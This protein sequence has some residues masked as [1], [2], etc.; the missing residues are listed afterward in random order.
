[1]VCNFYISNHFGFFII[2]HLV[3][4]WGFHLFSLIPNISNGCHEVGSMVH[5]DW[6]K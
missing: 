4:D 1:M 6:T 5:G 3:S 2:T